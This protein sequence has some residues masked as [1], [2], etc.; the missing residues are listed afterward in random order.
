MAKYIQQRKRIFI[1][2]E[3]EG[4]QSFVKWLQRL[5]DQNGLHVYLDCQPLGGG[6]YKTMLE[7]TVRECSRKG[8]SS[9]KSYILLVDS[10]R[11]ERGD[12]GWSLLQLKQESS[13]H[14]IN[15][16]VQTPNQEGL[17]VRMMP[18]NES[19]QPSIAKVQNQLRSIWPDYQKPVDAQTLASKFGLNDLLRVAHIDSELKMLQSIKG[20]IK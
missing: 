16:C 13:K 4:E 5:S 14:K 6:G 10:D 11:A 7:K 1:A 19:L 9:A 12:D 2:G 20:F 18:G 15:V 17:L 8:R 3:G